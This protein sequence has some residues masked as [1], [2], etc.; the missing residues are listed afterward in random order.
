MTEQHMERSLSPFFSA[1]SDVLES[2]SARILPRAHVSVLRGM[3]DSA[4]REM[5]EFVVNLTER[6]SS[7]G[8]AWK[9]RQVSPRDCNPSLR[10]SRGLPCSAQ[11]LEAWAASRVPCAYCGRSGSSARP[12]SPATPVDRSK[13]SFS[14]TIAPTNAF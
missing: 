12:S 6:T 8:S 13:R 1:A 14:L 3:W 5:Y 9:G 4:C 10:L 2:C 11:P 7:S